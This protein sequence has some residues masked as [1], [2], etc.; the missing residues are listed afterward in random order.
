MSVTITWRFLLGACELIHIFVST[1]KEK[2]NNFA[3]NIRQI[4]LSATTMRQGL[5]HPCFC[6]CPMMT[7]ENHGEMPAICWDL[8]N[9]KYELRSLVKTTHCNAPSTKS[10]P[11]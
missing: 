4:L 3:E 7:E 9:T 10:N 2:G 1:G 5:A 6:R 8:P 11:Q